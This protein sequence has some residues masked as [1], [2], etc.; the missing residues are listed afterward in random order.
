MIQIVTFH[1]TESQNQI[2][3]SHI[4]PPDPETFQKQSNGH[5]SDQIIYF[6]GR[7]SKAVLNFICDGFQLG[8]PSK[9]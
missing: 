4:E 3:R 1:V 8:S 7:F 2:I 5:E 6:I 9:T